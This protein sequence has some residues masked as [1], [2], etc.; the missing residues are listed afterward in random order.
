MGLRMAKKPGPRAREPR[1]K[2]A[3]AHASAPSRCVVC[4]WRMSGEWKDAAGGLA[5]CE[6]CGEALCAACSFDPERLAGHYERDAEHYLTRAEAAFWIDEDPRWARMAGAS[7]ISVRETIERIL[8]TRLRR[9]MG[10]RDP[11]RSATRFLR[12]AQRTGVESFATHLDRAFAARIYAMDL[13]RELPSQS[14]LPFI[15][16]RSVQGDVVEFEPAADA[17]PT[18]PPIIAHYLRRRRGDEESEDEG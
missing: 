12:L 3:P 16:A 14:P 17:E 18:L 10:M 5:H 4:G 1:T 11:K 7:M 6:V 15:P 13:R 8:D 2:T 9:A